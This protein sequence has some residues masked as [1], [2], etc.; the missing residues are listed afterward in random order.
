MGVLEVW[1]DALAEDD[2]PTM[3]VPEPRESGVRLKVAKVA[4]GS[5]MIDVVTCDL[6]RDRRS[7]CFRDANREAARSGEKPPAMSNV[8]ALRGR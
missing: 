6:S 4:Y 3:P 8:R 5:A 2:R 7:E 1:R